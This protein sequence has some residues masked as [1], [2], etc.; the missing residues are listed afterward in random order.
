MDQSRHLLSS[1]KF[2]DPGG[3]VRAA[4]QGSADDT[5]NYDFRIMSSQ[6]QFL[7]PIVENIIFI[8]SLN[9]DNLTE[10]LESFQL[11]SAPQQGYPSFQ[12]PLPEGSAFQS[13]IIEIIDDD[14]KL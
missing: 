5:E 6:L 8:F 14:C 2:T 13:T 12:S 4:T 3:R 7:S 1:L 10:G 9:S 11:T